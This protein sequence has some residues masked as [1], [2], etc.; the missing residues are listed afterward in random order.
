MFVLSALLFIGVG[1]ALAAFMIFGIWSDFE[2]RSIRKLIGT[3]AVLFILTGFLHA[4]ARG[5]CEK[6]TEN[7]KR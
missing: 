7:G 4:V 1:I 5:A 2:D 6:G 3:L